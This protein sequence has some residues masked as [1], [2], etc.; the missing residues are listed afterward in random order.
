MKGFIRGL[1]LA[2]C[3]S[4]IVGQ[5]W[6]EAVVSRDNHGTVHG[7]V[8]SPFPFD[9]TMAKGDKVYT[10]KLSHWQKE[11]FILMASSAMMRAKNAAEFD[12]ALTL[13]GPSLHGLFADIEGSIGYRHTGFNPERPAGFDPRFPLPGTGEAEWTGRFLPNAHEMNPAKGYF[14]GWNNKASPDTRNTFHAKDNYHSFGRYHRSLWLDRALAGRKGLDVDTNKE[15]IRYLGGAGTWQRN[16]HN[17][18]GG[19]SKD[20]LSFAYR[21]LCHARRAQAGRCGRIQ[22]LAFGTE[23]SYLSGSG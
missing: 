6:G 23:R 15:I 2:L 4:L 3:F 17:A 5:A 14:C 1:F 18:L 21:D 16:Q 20:M 19:M 8:F 9:P 10:R 22:P 11:H 12:R 7:P 13:W